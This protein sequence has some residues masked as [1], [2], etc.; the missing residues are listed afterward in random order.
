MLLNGDF[1][2]EIVNSKEVINY[3][4][5]Q[6]NYKHLNL[7]KKIKRKRKLKNDSN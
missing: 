4:M 6:Q 7:V 1:P 3:I 5:D 2:S